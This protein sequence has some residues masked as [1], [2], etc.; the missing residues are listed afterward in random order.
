MDSLNQIHFLYQ[1]SLRM[2]LDIFS[3]VLSRDNPSLGGKSDYNERLKLITTDLF[4]V[5]YDRI[6]RGMLHADR[7]TFAILLCRIHLKGTSE[8]SLDAEFNFFLRSREGIMANPQHIEGFTAEQIEGANRLAN[9]LPIFKK[10]IEKIKSMPEILAWLNQGSP[11]QN[12]PQLWDDSR[13]L[14]PIAQAVHRLL[15]IQAFRPDRVIA[16]GSLFVSNV[17]G[18]E[19]MPLAGK[20]LDFAACVEKQLT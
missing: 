16:A 19:F 1:Y 11:E 9:R 20:E 6:A 18:D 14:S 3:T 17:L 15:L 10:L 12:V 4:S 8:Q 2:F 5:V 7:L 13:A